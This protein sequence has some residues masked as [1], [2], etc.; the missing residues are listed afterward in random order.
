MA[1]YEAV[2]PNLGAR[3]GR[4]EGQV[5]GI[6]KMIDSDRYCIDVVTQINAV[7]RALEE[8]GLVLLE[9]HTKGCVRDALK[10][11]DGDEQVAELAA[12][13]SRFIRG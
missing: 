3:L 1:S 9:E 5:R 2:K 12:T 4:I 6:K 8:V 10:E 7:R 13:V 11:G